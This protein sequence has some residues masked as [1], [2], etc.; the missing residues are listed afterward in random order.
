MKLPTSNREVLF[1]AA[2]V[3]GVPTEVNDE[4]ISVTA[5][6]ESVG[7]GTVLFVELSP[8]VVGGITVEDV[9]LLADVV[10]AVVALGDMVP[11]VFADVNLVEAIAE[12]TDSVTGRAV[13]F[14]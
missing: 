2:A 14:P 4:L 6:V 11:L 7:T 1:G 13:V 8:F 9:F 3:P 5:F 10:L 12:V